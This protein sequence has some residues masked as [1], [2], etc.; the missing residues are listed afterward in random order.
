MFL[1]CDLDKIWTMKK[2]YLLSRMLMN[3]RLYPTYKL[4]IQQLQSLE[5]CWTTWGSWV[6][7]REEFITHS[8]S[9]SLTLHSS[10]PK[11]SFHRYCEEGQVIPVCAVDCIAANS[12]AVG[13][14][15]SYHR[16]ARVSVVCV[17]RPH[18]LSFQD[19]KQTSPLLWRELLPLSF[20]ALGWKKSLKRFFQNEVQDSISYNIQKC[21]FK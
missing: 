7:D 13:T 16:A 5:H 12:W 15:T 17:G 8:N 3:L 20:K 18:S 14:P 1:I 10:S 11:S 21:E 9:Q 19:C 6:R 2:R 4:L